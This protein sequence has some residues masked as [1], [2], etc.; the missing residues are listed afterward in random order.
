M[1]RLIPAIA[2]IL[3]WASVAWTAAPPPLTTLRAIA[4]LTNDQA[5]QRLPVAFEATVTYYA[6]S[7][8]NLDVQDGETGIYIK[9]TTDAMLLP[10]DR[11]LVEGTTQP[12]FLPY[13]LGNKITVLG[14]GNLPK[15][16][17]AGFDD[18]VRTNVNCMLVRVRGVIRAADLLYSAIA[19]SG[20][21][22]LLAD[23][24]YIDLEVDSHDAAALNN[25]LDAQV[26]VTG[27]AGRTFDGKMQETG[28]KLKVSSLADI[29]VLDRAGESP[30]SLPVTPLAGIITGYHV[31][32]L[33][34]RLR[35]HGTIT[36]YQPGEAVVLQN[37]A[38]S[39]WISTQTSEPL[40]IGD[41]A[42]ATGFPDAHDGRLTLTH[43]EIRDSQLQAPVQPQSATW[44]QLAFWGRSQLG[45]REYDLVSIEGRVVTVL[46]EATQD[47]YVLVADGQE[48]TAVYRHPPPPRPLPR[49]LQVPVGST[50]RVT[51][52]C[53][54]LDA[55]P[56]NNQ[57][58]FDILMRSFDDIQVVGR[59]SLL[60][61]RNLM[62]LIGL[63]LAV[64]IAAG[65][66]EWT[67]ERKV[68]RQTANVAYLE[69]RRRRILE[70]ISGS[71]PL[72]E[73]IEQIT[74]VV[75]FRLQGAPCWCEVTDGA[76]L[77]NCPPN[78]TA[79][80]ILEN[81]IP[82]HSGIPLGTIF[83]AFNSLTKSGTEESEALAM[84]AGLAALAIETRRLYSDLLHRSEFD[85]LTD[86][87]NRFSLERHLDQMIDDA[88]RTAGIFGLIY[89]DLDAFK[90]VNDVY[91]HQVGDSY[92]Q[93]V[94][95][96][97]K[98]QLRPGDLLARLGGDEF[99]ALVPVVHNRS[100]VEE[101]AL[102]LER[103]FDEPFVVEGCVL[104]GSAS[105]GIA[106]YP[107]D[108]ATKDSLL[109]AADG[110]MYEAKRTRRRMVQFLAD[111]LGPE[112]APDRRT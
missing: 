49:M 59:P 87:E 60:T 89:I 93:Q 94:A 92:L 26:E 48:F 72:A 21:L 52:I 9:L 7:L 83:A 108:A 76:R 84:G 35:V 22:E 45:G 77:G 105:V 16:I 10:G 11:V 29:K 6:R 61:I 106:L 54:P 64:V 5:A 107:A 28:A 70:D 43:A 31:H 55:N 69:R 8:R 30:W 86:I 102:R 27:V 50:I 68:R 75:S 104:H 66:R 17:P 39:L 109:S 90:Q 91:G 2:L 3:G 80:R 13:V 63:L 25:L 71:R 12:S 82:S 62:I 34:Q 65:L 33:T 103:S 42:D 88:R 56:F 73:I 57:T 15:P 20:H 51:G 53:V 74:E 85:L 24:G 38:S 1:K 98:R 44:R 100:D 36:Y 4:V 46:R 110:T 37:G 95:E 97:M 111:E 19:P 40:Q 79:L 112:V 18:L 23:G 14:H 99:G 81:K 47:E 41:M 101:I 58:P 78:L 67:L 32:D 96:R